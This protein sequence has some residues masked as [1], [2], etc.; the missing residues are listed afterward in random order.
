[1]V[2]FGPFPISF[3]PANEFSTLLYDIDSGNVKVKIVTIFPPR[4]L[5]ETFF[6]LPLPFHGLPS[7]RCTFRFCF[8]HLLLR[9]VAL[10]L[11]QPT[12]FDITQSPSRLLGIRT[13]FLSFSLS[14]SENR[15]CN[16]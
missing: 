2:E 13:K 3:M 15:K 16:Y 11:T 12:A 9:Y 1:M 14:N 6:L 7:W 4:G 8:G 10:I 5:H